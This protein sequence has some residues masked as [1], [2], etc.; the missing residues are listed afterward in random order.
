MG[1]KK[2]FENITA[3]IGLAIVRR[4]SPVLREAIDNPENLK[5]E[6]YIDGDEFVIKVKIKEEV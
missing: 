2:Y 3:K 4:M 5:F 1:I 6:G